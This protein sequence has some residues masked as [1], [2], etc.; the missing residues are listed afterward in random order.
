MLSPFIIRVPNFAYSVQSVDNLDFDGASKHGV[1]VEE[2]PC[3][4]PFNV[5]S[6]LEVDR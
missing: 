5:R 4:K 3:F 2:I 1:K 6:R